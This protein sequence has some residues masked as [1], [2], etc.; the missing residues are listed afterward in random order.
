LSSNSNIDYSDEAEIKQLEE[1]GEGIGLRIDQ[2]IKN[3]S[4][5]N[6]VGIQ[7]NHVS[8]SQ[9]LDSRTYFVRDDR[10]GQGKAGGVFQGSSMEQLELSRMILDKAGIPSSE[11]LDQKV[12][13]EKTQVAQV[14]KETKKI[15]FEDVQN[16]RGLAIISRQIDSLPVWSSNFILGITSEKQIGYMEIHWPEIPKL[17]VKEA[18]RLDYKLQHG[19]SPPKLERA[20]VE[21]VD[22]GIIHSP[23]ISFFMDIYPVIRV[24]YA[25]DK[26]CGMKPMLFLDRDGK[27]VPTPRQIDL[28][29]EKTEQRKMQHEKT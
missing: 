11:I 24:I 21:S 3:G 12:L 9:R 25:P 4:V 17:T 28:K 29:Y 27:N 10:Y 15:H 8:F 14:D 16:G 5:A 7:S 26:G 13:Q 18:H 23:A 22:A 1:F 19:W 20:T 2:I 6:I